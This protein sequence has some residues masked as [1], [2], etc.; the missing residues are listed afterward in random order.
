M[1]KKTITKIEAAGPAVKT[2]RVAAYC[3]ISTLNE[4]Q[5]SSMENQLD[6]YENLIT[7]H[8][9]WKLVDIY[10]EEGVTGTKKDVRPELNRLLSDCRAHKIDL[11]LTKSISRFARNTTDCLQMIR[12]LTDLGVRIIFEKE[13]LDTAQRGNEFVL[14]ILS[15]IAE[16]ES[17]SISENEKWSI[18]KRFQ[19]GSYY[20]KKAPYGFS[21]ENGT[22]IP[23]P[24][25]SAVVQW[26]FDKVLEGRGAYWISREL[27]KARIPSPEDKTWCD[28]TVR[29]IIRNPAAIG[30]VLM[31]KTYKDKNYKRH[32]NFGERP[33][34]YN[35]GH[36]AAIIDRET[37]DLA[38]KAMTQRG[39]E[40]G[41]GKESMETK[42]R[43][44]SKYNNRYP[45]SGKLICGEC[46]SVF[47]RK[48]QYN[49]S[50]ERHRWT[51]RGH[52]EEK[53]QCS[54]MPVLEEDVKNAFVTMIK[55]LRYAPFI[56][57][58]YCDELI[59]KDRQEHT[60]NLSRIE[61]KLKQNTE[62]RNR[63]ALLLQS[64]VIEP[65]SFNQELI[66]L[67]D[68]AADLKEKRNEL[69]EVRDNPAAVFKKFVHGFHGMEFPDEGFTE[70]VEKVIIHSPTRFTFVLNCGLELTEDIKLS[71]ASAN[72]A[73][74][75]AK[76]PVIVNTE[77]KNTELEK[78]AV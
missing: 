69:M 48:T 76:T 53:D 9:G 4:N 27:N 15:T 21:W 68:A 47:K 2:L 25:E 51:C 22:F 56:F 61:E 57:D 17:H 31:N 52:M 34:Y 44:K 30:D 19:D 41:H 67:E 7:H 54:M 71:T 37:F 40:K 3:R 60:E 18:Q 63:L 16:E 38:Q 73:P 13:G 78:E 12:E 32:K 75:N 62:A 55:K 10:I 46:G 29:G 1:A 42:I 20:F 74:A 58:D 70:H 36:H 23:D 72:T 49:V 35:E 43:Q 45:F 8:E 14:T 59:R 11:I 5:L 26:I 77:D 50:G 24:F 28:Y 64:G 66:R 33:M 6:H 65:V 39:R